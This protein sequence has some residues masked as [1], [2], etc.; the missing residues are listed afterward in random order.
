MMVSEKV[1]ERGKGTQE[2]EM[3]RPGITGNDSDVNLKPDVRLT[4]QA[5]FESDSLALALTQA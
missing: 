3:T 5:C 1:Q 2:R 4:Q